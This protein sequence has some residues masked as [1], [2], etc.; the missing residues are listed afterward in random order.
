VLLPFL[1]MVTALVDG[2]WAVFAKATL[3]RA[4]RLGVRTGVTL[5]SSQMAQGA[6]LTGTVKGV[7]QANAMGLL[8]SGTGSSGYALIKVHYFQPPAAS[9]NSAAT[10][11]SGNS[12][13]DQPGNIM[14]VSVQNYSVVP[15]LPRIFNWKTAPDK[16]PLVIQGVYSADL[17][18]P[19][20]I[21]DRPCIGTAP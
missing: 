7:V 9:S 3:Q 11:V 6:C 16:N 19:A 13:G 12:D 1:A 10:D 4:V 5:T 17:I 14:Q 15:L 21:T 2:S 20:S 8:G 18:E